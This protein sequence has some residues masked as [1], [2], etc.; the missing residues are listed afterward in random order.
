MYFKQ[1]I[2]LINTKE[3]NS[4]DILRLQVF[5]KIWKQLINYTLLHRINKR[6]LSKSAYGLVFSKYMNALITGTN[7]IF[8]GSEP[9][10]N[11]INKSPKEARSRLGLP[12]QGRLA[13][14]Q[15]F[16][17]ASKG[18]D[19]ISNMGMLKNWKLVVNYSKNFYNTENTGLDLKNGKIIDQVIKLN[20]QYLS[21]EK[22]SL[23][24]F[25]CDAVFLP[26]K[27]SSGSGVMYDGLAHGKPFIASDIGFFKE[28]SANEP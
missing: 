25:S 11:T 8:H 22:L 28:F 10:S 27:V 1:W 9:W 14:A 12:L 26:Y 5:H 2:Q 4:R 16:F 24:L 17:T 15:G 23:L 21:K 7:L 18:W 3:S 19:I 13:L 20:K 6:I